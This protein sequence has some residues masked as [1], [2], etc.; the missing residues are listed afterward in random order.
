MIGK[1]LSLCIGTSLQ[2]HPY[3][4]DN[5]QTHSRRTCAEWLYA[6]VLHL[7][8][9]YLMRSLPRYR[10]IAQIGALAVVLWLWSHNSLNR[11]GAVPVAHLSVERRERWGGTTVNSTAWKGEDRRPLLL[12]KWQC[13]AKG[14]AVGR[15]MEAIWTD[16]AHG[17]CSL[18]EASCACASVIFSQQ[19]HSSHEK[20]R[21]EW[22]F[23]F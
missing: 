18:S 6:A 23:V 4:S 14:A 12:S 8:C 21:W 11:L 20:S 2:K 17:L 16:L 22:V 7:T 5:E 19:I 1:M 3:T 9:S 13:T 15:E 10:W